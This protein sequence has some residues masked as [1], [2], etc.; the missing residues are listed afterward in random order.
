[1]ENTV[2]VPQSARGKHG[3][4]KKQNSTLRPVGLHTHATAWK[5]SHGIVEISGEPGR[6]KHQNI[7]TFTDHE[8]I[9]SDLIYQR[10]KIS[11]RKGQR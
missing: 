8:A 4:H 11:P 3:K 10:L 9:S 1:M 5:H 7:P 2:T 6:S